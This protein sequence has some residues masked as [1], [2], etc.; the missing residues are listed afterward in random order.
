MAK[1]CR[2]C[3]CSD[4]TACFHEDHGPCWWVGADLC[5]HCQRGIVCERVEMAVVEEY[6]V[7]EIS[8]A[9]DAAVK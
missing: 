2:E 6:L 5:S 9:L 8:D 3:G 7:E 4:R 1:I